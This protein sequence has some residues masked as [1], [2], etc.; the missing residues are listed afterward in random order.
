MRSTR[1][2]IWLAPPSRDALISERLV[3]IAEMTG[4][5]AVAHGA[6][7]KATIRSGLSWS[8]YAL[9]PDSRSS[10]LGGNGSVIAHQASLEF[11]EHTNRIPIAKDKRGE[12][13][14][15]V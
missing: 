9:N 4:A 1:G 15:G 14:L 13:R 3:E 6:T 11:A 7:A 8:A 2:C 12:P 5:D 10:L